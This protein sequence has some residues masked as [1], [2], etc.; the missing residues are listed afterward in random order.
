MIPEMLEFIT[1][2]KLESQEG[3]YYQ[4][5]NGVRLVLAGDGETLWFS[6]AP[7][8]THLTTADLEFAVIEFL[9]K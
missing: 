5:S 2:Q 6:W 3:H 8:M 7:E 1:V 9:K 4:A